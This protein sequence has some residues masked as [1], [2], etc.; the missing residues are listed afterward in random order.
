[1][2][3]HSGPQWSGAERLA[4]AIREILET[5]AGWSMTGPPRA[6][7]TRRDG[8]RIDYVCTTYEVDVVDTTEPT[9]AEC[10]DLAKGFLAE[11]LTLVGQTPQGGCLIWRSPP[12][13]KCENGKIY[14]RA[15][16]AVM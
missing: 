11:A 9:A 13:V 8:E 7:I 14:A 4:A 15:H 10:A 16:F 2:I 1:M 12:H 5:T 6:Y 3:A